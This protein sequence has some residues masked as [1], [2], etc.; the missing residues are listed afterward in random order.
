MVSGQ[1]G[2]FALGDA[3]HGFFEFTLNPGADPV[4]MTSALESVR[5]PRSTVAGAKPT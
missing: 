5:V 4:A 2:I 3:A 1:T